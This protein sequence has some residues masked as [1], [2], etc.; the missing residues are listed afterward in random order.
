MYF[1]IMRRKS[2]GLIISLMTIALVG[3]MA[4][5]YFFIRQSFHLKSQLFD[6]SVMAA[7]KTVALKAEKD[8][9]L[10]FLHERDKRE[11]QAK[12]RREESQRQLLVFNESQQHAESMKIQNR[13]QHSNFLALEREVKRRH[14]GAVLIDNEF[15]ETYIKDARYRPFVQYQASVRHEIDE[16]GALLKQQDFEI[17]VTRKAPVIQPAKDDSVRYFVIDPQFGEL[18][19]ALPPRIDA[20]LEREIRKHEQLAKAK[21]AASYMDSIRNSGGDAGLTLENLAIEFERSK[22]SIVKRIDPKFIIEQLS[23][24]LELRNI[25]IDFSWKIEKGNSDS[26]LFQQANYKESTQDAPY[27]AVLFPSEIA[28]NEAIISVYFPNKFSVLLSNGRSILLSSLSLILIL[29]G[30]FSYTI[31]SILKQKKL[32]E[33]KND[34]INNMTHEF[35]TPVATIMIASESLKDQDIRRDEQRVQRLANIIYDENI[36]LGDHI[37]RVLNIARIDKGDLKF[38]MK[39]INFHELL[40]GVVG[41]MDL[42]VEK[43]KA[44]IELK[45]KAQEV[46][47]LADELHLSNVIFNL[48]DNALKYCKNNPEIKIHTLNK[49]NQLIVT[50]SDNGV[51]MNKDQLTRI[52]D[53]FYRIPTGNIH[54]V[55]GF[56]LGLSYVND[57]VKRLNG[58]IRVKSEINK[59]TE[60][61][62]HFPLK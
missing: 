27:S 17:F 25:P 11:Q 3:V 1:C 13:K 32:S 57:V 4:M 42:L 49:G 2:I 12:K 35:K 62:L 15:Y 9:A 40:E 58:T 55:K 24:E 10:R 18:I 45:L 36:R 30:C 28:G 21:I 8:E 19:L 33:M 39:N 47:I 20:R 43:K 59:G 46:F 34:F 23:E 44:R 61:E 50:I 60:F 37:E 29:I 51:G 48:L 38:S 6:E 54:D 5:Q 26:V 16:N 14:P 22:Q 31:F 56:G 7:L 41:S 52:F 53:Q